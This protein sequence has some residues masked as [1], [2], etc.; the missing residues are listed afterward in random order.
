MANTSAPISLRE[1]FR[2][3]FRHR[4]KIM[5]FC[6][7]TVVLAVAYILFCP[8][9]Y[10][11]EAKLYVRMGRENVAL[12]PT[13][14]TAQTVM[15]QRSQENEINS[16]L[17]ILGSRWIA[18]QVVDSVGVVDIL[19]NGAGKD[20]SGDETKT[21]SGSWIA[22]AIDAIRY[23]VSD[24]DRAIK[25]VQES[26]EVYSPKQSTV[27]TIRGNAGSPEL[28]QRITSATVDIFHDAHLHLNRTRGTHEFFAE[29]SKSLREE[30][31]DVSKKL[32]DR[33]NEY[34]MLSIE[35]RRKSLEEQIQAVEL[36][37]R[38]TRRKLVASRA[39]ARKL[40]QRLGSL[41]PRID[42]TVE[43]VAHEGWDR[44]RERLYALQL[45][46]LELKSR[47][48]DEFPKIAT[49]KKQRQEAQKLLK[50][51]ATDRTQVTTV[52]NPTY[53]A[54]QLEL[55]KQ[56]AVI[57]SHQSSHDLLVQQSAEL[58]A[59]LKAVNLQEFEVD[60]LQLQA[61]L[62]ETR[63]LKHAEKLEEARIDDAL[64]RQEISS[65]NVVQ[66]A[67][68]E[69]KPASPKRGLT[70]LSAI[71]ICCFGSVVIIA[72]GEQSN[73]RRAE[74]ESMNISPE[75]QDKPNR[76]RVRRLVRTPK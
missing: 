4:W 59:E 15:V 27:I 35:G 17:D 68:L 34:E 24:R 42:E 65:L 29:Q 9:T 38:A 69:S 14:T 2:M 23:P 55:S 10:V 12:D 33:K 32:C 44:M 72:L 20:T 63:Y 49:I 71:A 64:A 22:S 41:D 51:Q 58:A 3:A 45:E 26:M 18:E 8:E 48:T 13:V 61:S 67:T 70:L 66:P 25:Q 60:K 40:E 36:Q 46:E 76:R 30:L 19:S 6:T 31:T 37:E 73:A 1:C 28:A 75:Q 74:P 57:A 62:L 7:S 43:G 56:L 54:L 47:C 50:K 11:S 53:Y 16:L 52:P 39:Q 5:A 21:S